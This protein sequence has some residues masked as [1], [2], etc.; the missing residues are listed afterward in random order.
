MDPLE[1]EAC[2][3]HGWGANKADQR[4]V[5]SLQVLDYS[6]VFIPGHQDINL[7]PFT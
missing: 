1:V 4:G 6:N 3:A 2:G 7:P 5:I